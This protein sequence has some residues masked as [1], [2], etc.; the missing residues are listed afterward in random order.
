[1]RRVN[2]CELSD[3][4]FRSLY[5]AGASGDVSLEQTNGAFPAMLSG[6]T[7]TTEKWSAYFD[8]DPIAVLAIT[9]NAQLE[10]IVAGNTLNVT[11]AASGGVSPYTW[12]LA[13]GA[14]PAGVSLTSAGVLSGAPTTA[15]T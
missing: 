10:S 9:T 11:L 2:A 4:T 14:L 15:G 12:S 8:Y 5:T 3:N 13:S 1:M 6:T 7:S